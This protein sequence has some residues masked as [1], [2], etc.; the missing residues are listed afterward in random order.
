MNPRTTF[1]PATRAT[2]IASALA[3]LTV[4]P[5][6]AADAETDASADTGLESIVVTAT[7]REEPLQK[8]PTAVTVVSARDLEDGALRTTKDVAKFVPAA[9]GWNTESRARP[10]FFIRGVGSNEATNNAVNPIAYYADEV[11]YGNTLFAGAPLFDLDRVEVLRGPQGTLWGKNTTGGAF[12]FVSRAPEFDPDGYLR[13]EAGNLGSR[14]AEGAWGGALKDE[15]LAGRAALHYEKRGGLATNTVT[16]HE[17]GDYSDL[18]GRV[19]LLAVTSADTDALVEAHFRHLDGTQRPWYSVTRRGAPDRYGYTAPVGDGSGDLDHVAYNVDLPIEVESSGVR[20]VVHHRFDGYTLTSIT[21]FD[22][23]SRSSTVDSDYTPVEWYSGSGRA[24]AKNSVDQVSQELR[25][26]SPRN[27]DLSWQSGLYYFQDSNRS[28]G[29]TASL[30]GNAATQ[31]YYYTRFKQDTRS[32]ALF[33]NATYAVA[34]RFKLNGGARYTR[35]T[36]GIDLVTRS[37]TAAS[38]AYA[39]SGHWWQPQNLESPLA[40]Y[41]STNGRVANTWSNLGYDLTPEYTIDDNQ[42]LYFRHASGF[43]SGNYNTYI[44]PAS[45]LAT[46]SQFALVR[47]EKLK[48]YELGYK[49]SWLDK[50]LVLNAS[51]YH[52]DYRDMQLV[53]NQVYGGV[54]YPTLA[55]A[56]RGKVDGVE[57]E[58]AWR[59]TRDLKL[60]LNLSRLKTRFNELVANGR[61][62]A[63]FNFARVPQ[64]TALVGADYRLAVGSG[65]LTLGADWTYTSKVNFNVTDKTDPYALQTGYSLGSLH[66][67]YAF[68]HERLVVGAYVNNVADKRYKVQ[69]MLYQGGLSDGSGGHYPTA[70]GDPRTFGANLTYRF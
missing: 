36:V 60:R 46:V 50:R 16:G 66:A 63:G 5:A 64:T 31:K 24:Y 53:V 32:A 45:A 25:I 70:Y 41:F 61:S 48:S 14:V 19:Q 54:F 8:V 62:Y 10:R 11:Y 56:G 12:H 22:S 67:S 6:H 28:L 4:A 40:T 55:N 68:D 2:A 30:T 1:R 3:C 20:A 35:E 59:A 34:E 9:Q 38:S 49:S 29:T 44:N 43:R 42:L 47:P 26:A 69:A 7:R 23:G 57:L 51:A 37:A 39:F 52:Y 18:A 33:G 21:A 58:T 15:V 17:V 13:L 65:L 27:A